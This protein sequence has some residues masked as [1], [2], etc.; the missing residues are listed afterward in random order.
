MKRRNSH[1]IHI[2]YQLA[3]LCVAV[4]YFC[5]QVEVF[6]EEYEKNNPL[7]SSEL[8]FTYSQY[9]WESF[10]KTNAPKAFVFVAPV[11]FI[12]LCLCPPAIGEELPV[13]LPFRLVQ[14]NS[15]PDPATI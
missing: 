5:F 3:A 4:N 6:D 13:F 12:L 11:D 8:S 7:P 10:D 14:N 1:S 15:P 9:N 2:I